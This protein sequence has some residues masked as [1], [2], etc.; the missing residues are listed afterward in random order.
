MAKTQEKPRFSPHRT[1]RGLTPLSVA[2]R[3]LV[4]T[5]MAKRGFLVSSL[6]TS[7][8]DIVGQELACASCPEKISFPTDRGHKGT[9]LLKVASGH[10][11]VLAHM[12]LMIIDRI[13]TYFGHPYIGKI[14]II[15][16]A[17]PHLY[18]NLPQSLDPN[19]ASQ[20]DQSQIG[21]VV[22][23]VS[24]TDLRLTLSRIGRLVWVR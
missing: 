6:V 17:F 21:T 3:P 22:E 19:S 4:K 7:W 20:S 24:D 13:N 15:Q 2:I 10:G 14:K 12:E 11:P 8:S 18:K 16:G 9:L 23:P 5:S 1:T